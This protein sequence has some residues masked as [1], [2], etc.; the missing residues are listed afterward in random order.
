MAKSLTVGG[1]N[2]RKGYYLIRTDDSEDNTGDPVRFCAGQVLPYLW[3]LVDR[4][5]RRQF[6]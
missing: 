6:N 5:N 3:R 1:H 2:V 4:F